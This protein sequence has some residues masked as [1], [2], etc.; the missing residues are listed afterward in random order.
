MI[1]NSSIINKYL[2][3]NKHIAIFFLCTISCDFTQVCHLVFVK[4]TEETRVGMRRSFI[5]SLLLTS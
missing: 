4:P 5:L 3:F 1:Y 2:T